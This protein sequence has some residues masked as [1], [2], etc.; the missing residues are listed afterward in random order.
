MDRPQVYAYLINQV[1]IKTGEQHLCPWLL[2][3]KPTK[4]NFKISDIET[5]SF[6]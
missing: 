3:I 6:I 5:N 2:C 4:H 1:S